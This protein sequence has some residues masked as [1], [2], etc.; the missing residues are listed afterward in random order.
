M[1]IKGVIF[2]LDG[3]IVTTDNFHYDAW[4]KLAD[5]EGIYFDREINERL[6][7]VSRMESLNIIL[8]K[9]NKE[10]SLEQKKEMAER[11][12]NYY[13]ELIKNLTK[14]DILP[15]VKNILKGLKEKNIK[16]AIGSSSKNSSAILQYIGL[17]KAF[18]ATVDGNQ[19]KNSKPD[20]EVFLKAAEMLNLKP[21]ECLVVED[22]EAGVEAGVEG[23]MKVLAV[24]FAS[25]CCSK[26][27]IC[28]EDLTTISI[29]EIVNI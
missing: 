14:D 22:A 29:D 25:K 21:S 18:H 12:N 26:A 10:Y 19:I 15:G 5:E 24:G 3:V 6:R 8:E 20:P 1:S 27:T 13:K 17:D 16:V 2:D 28:R 7:G 4:K 9:A 11:K 23:G